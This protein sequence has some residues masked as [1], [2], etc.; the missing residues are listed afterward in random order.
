[1]TGQRKRNVPQV[2]ASARTKA[3][4]LIPN[5]RSA[6]SRKAWK[7]YWLLDPLEGLAERSVFRLLRMLPLEWGSRLGGYHGRFIGSARK[8]THE[9]ARRALAFISPELSQSE[10][11]ATLNRLRQNAG[12]A[13]VETLISDRI[14][15]ADHVV[16]PV[17]PRRSEIRDAAT[18]RIYVTIHTSNLGYLMG[19][20]LRKATGLHVT[21]VS[22]MLPNRFSQRLS[23]TLYQQ[24]EGKVLGP[25]ISTARHLMEHL[26][27]PGGLVLIHIDE[28]RSRQVYFPTFGRE[29]PYGSNLSLAIRL[30]ATTGAAIV[31][32]Y[33]K[34]TSGTHFELRVLPDIAAP[35]KDDT[36][37][38]DVA[39][40]LD[41]LFEKIIRDNIDDWQQLYFL[42]P[43]TGE[44]TTAGPDHV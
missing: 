25:G 38:A 44:S 40:Q 5:W 10:V 17:E 12:R 39:R 41:V 31:P 26:R 30:A 33:L 32:V 15:A 8:R 42:R 20:A 43:P 22:R 16:E 37:Q 7:R 14:S 36:E 1:M 27:K 9:Q 11:A 3:P 18:P 19:I 24:H 35:A 23:E 29:M 13:L 2:R 34:R 4:S 21:T 6:S 28:A